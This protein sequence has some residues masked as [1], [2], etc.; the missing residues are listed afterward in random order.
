MGFNSQIWNYF[1]G[2]S[3]GTLYP[4]GAFQELYALQH[5]T[6]TSGC[7]AHLAFSTC[8]IIFLRVD[9]KFYGNVEINFH[10]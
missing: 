4:M 7:S 3:A 8:I 10:I 2:K 9:F 6:L 5:L 1:G